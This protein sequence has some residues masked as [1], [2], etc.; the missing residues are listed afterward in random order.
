MGVV[1]SSQSPDSSFPARA[2]VDDFPR[3]DA[4]WH[5]ARVKLET[6]NLGL[7]WLWIRLGA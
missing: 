2:L 1:S 4:T 5:F 6:E 7:F 3:R